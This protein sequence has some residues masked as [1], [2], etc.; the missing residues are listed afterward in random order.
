MIV[1]NSLPV[2]KHCASLHASCE[3]WAVDAHEVAVSELGVATKRWSSDWCLFL[4]CCWCCIEARWLRNRCLVSPMV[5]QREIGARRMRKMGKLPRWTQ[6]LMGIDSDYHQRP[7]SAMELQI[8]RQCRTCSLYGTSEAT[9]YSDTDMGL[10]NLLSCF[11]HTVFF[12]ELAILEPSTPA[13]IPEKR[14]KTTTVTTG[15][16]VDLR[17]PSVFL[18]PTCVNVCLNWLQK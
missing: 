3:T 17:S 7:R 9:T 5:W 13:P 8:S 6:K 15:Q 11:I 18:L 2:I 14:S 10:A 12:S 1:V 4:S 16:I